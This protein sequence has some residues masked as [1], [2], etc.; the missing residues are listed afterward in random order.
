[1]GVLEIVRKSKKVFLIFF[2]KGFE[3][4]SVASVTS[5]SLN[6]VLREMIQVNKSLLSYLQH[7]QSN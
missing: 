2:L 4:I 6:E 3:M 7:L 1:M 5:N